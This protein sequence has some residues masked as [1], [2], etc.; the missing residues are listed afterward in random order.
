MQERRDLPHR[1]LLIEDDPQI[2]QLV[3]TQFRELGYAVE[4]L[5]DGTAGLRCLREGTFDLLILDLLLPGLG[6]LEI[7][8]RIR[9]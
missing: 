6:G 7:C 1:V 3:V 4:W 5:Q 8:Q 2:G 9:E